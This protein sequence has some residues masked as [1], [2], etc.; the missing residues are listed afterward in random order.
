VAEP[1][2]G[3]E[4]EIPRQFASVPPP[5][6]AGAGQ[7]RLLIKAIEDAV[8]DLKDDVKD[9]KSHRHTDFVFHI[10]IFAGG[11][12]ILAGMFIAGYLKLDER[13]TAITNISIRVDTKLEDLLQRIPPLPSP[14]PRR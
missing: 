1:L 14:V 10:S 8:K 7:T 4:S 2:P 5:D 11:F 13:V 6:L 12:L 3:Q 9:I